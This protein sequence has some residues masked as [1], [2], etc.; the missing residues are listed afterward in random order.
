MGKDSL[1]CDT[2]L[3]L[4]LGRIKNHT[5]LQSLFEEVYVTEQVALELDAGRLL[6]ADA[7]NSRLFDWIKLVSISQ[8][9][10][11]VLPPNHLLME[12][13]ITN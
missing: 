12:S 5:L 9:D 7:I 1:V 13:G 6:R 2:S 3:L 11:D 10:I 4:Y 8:E